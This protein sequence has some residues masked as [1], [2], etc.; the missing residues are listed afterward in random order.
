[1]NFVRFFLGTPRRFLVSLLTVLAGVII[2][3]VVHHMHPG[4]IRE[5]V[6]GGLRELVAALMPFV[7][8]ALVFA[9]MYLG[10]RMMLNG[11]TGGQR[12]NR[13]NN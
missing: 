5:S 6:R 3:G 11:V 1:M 8:L 12:Q 4:L 13:R 2:L 9:V 7:Q 10:F